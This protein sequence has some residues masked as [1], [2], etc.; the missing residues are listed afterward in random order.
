MER[1]MKYSLFSLFILIVITF[2][3]ACCYGQSIQIIGEDRLP[4]LSY[5]E[6]GIRKGMAVE[7]VQATLKELSIDSRISL[8]P[9]ARAYWMA[10]HEKNTLIFPMSR[11]RE[12]ES[13]FKWVGAIAPNTSYLF[14]L[15]SR[16]DIK[17]ESLDDLK[18]YTI[19]TLIDG[20]RNNY[21]NGKGLGGNLQQTASLKENYYKLKSNRIDLW[22]S[23]ELTASYIIQSEGDDP[24]LIKKAYKL[25]G[26]PSNGYF[27]AFSFDTSDEIVKSFKKAL[28]KI[29][30]DGTYQRIEAKYIK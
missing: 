26:L 5:E 10:S 6:N 24:A 23:N 29:K 13:M 2:R 20:F 18:K 30:H 21:L 15:S 3:V 22:S 11:T 27:M 19:G 12:R 16:T 14:A 8:Y 28:E 17:I 9:W 4:P 25:D 1:M 7:V